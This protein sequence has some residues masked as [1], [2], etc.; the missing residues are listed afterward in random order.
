[1]QTIHAPG[2]ALQ[3]GRMARVSSAEQD[4]RVHPRYRSHARIPSPPRRDAV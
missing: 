3:E 1:M 4:G 2:E